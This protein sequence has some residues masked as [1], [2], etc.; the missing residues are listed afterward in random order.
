[1]SPAPPSPRPSGRRVELVAHRGANHPE[2]FATARALADLLE[3]D[4]HLHRGRLEVRHA[5]R[6][7]LTRRH[8]ERWYLVA[9]GTDFPLL[10]ELV[11][12]A[13]R[14]LHLMVDL[15]GVRR[16]LASRVAAVVGHHHLVTV[17]TKA[18]WLLR[19]FAADARVRT[20]R[21][22]GN[23]F[24]LFLLRRLRS[25]SWLGGVVVHQRLL[26]RRLVF[27][28]RARHDHLFTWAVEDRRRAV[29]LAGWGVTGLILDDLDLLAELDATM[30]G[31]GEDPAVE[32]GLD[33][34]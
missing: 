26:T 23:R 4:V 8:W 14:E 1:M 3:V 24:E 7:W 2:L 27:E 25:P 12:P 11:D 30:V 33:E 9:R 13:D 6:L 22:A 17:S 29:E 28:L 34:P 18:W 20:L 31:P 32:V 15:K 16:E 5:K 21:S 19:A 10:E